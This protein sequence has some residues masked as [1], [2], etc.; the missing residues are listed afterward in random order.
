MFSHK[1]LVS[2]FSI[3]PDR[4]LE[5][6]GYVVSKS[7]TDTEIQRLEKQDFHKCMPESVSGMHLGGSKNGRRVKG[8]RKAD[9][10]GEEVLPGVGSYEVKMGKRWF[11]VNGKLYEKEKDEELVAVMEMD[12]FPETF[13]V[14]SQ[15]LMKIRPEDAKRRYKPAGKKVKPVA[16]SGLKP[17]QLG[18]GKTEEEIVAEM[19]ERKKTEP[20][21]V[22]AERL[23][24]MKIGKVEEGLL[25]PQERQLFVEMLL[26]NDKALA[27]VDAERGRVDPAIVPPARINT[28]PHTPWNYPAPRYAQKEEE[29]IVAYIKEK[30]KNFVAEFS[31][32]QYGNRWFVL[33]KKSGTLR[34]IQDLQPLNKVTVRDVGTVPRIDRILEK[35]AGR[36]IYTLLDMFSGYDEMGLHPDDRHLTA[37]HMPI[38]L[39]QLMVVPMGGTTSV[40]MFQRCMT[41]VLHD[42]QEDIEIYVDDIPVL[43]AT[44]DNADWTELGPGVRRVVSAHVEKVD[45]IL[46][47]IEGAN[48]T[49]SGLKSIFGVKKLRILGLECSSEGLRPEPNKVKVILEWSEEFKEVGDIY[50]FLGLVGWF[51]AHIQ[52]L[53]AKVE[54]LRRLTRRGVEW[55][56]GKEERET[57][58]KLKAEFADGGNLLV[59]PIFREGE[60]WK[61]IVESDWGPHG[62]GGHLA[63]RRGDEKDVRTVRFAGGTAS[64]AERN[65]SQV[66]G[67]VLAVKKA[68]AAFRHYIYGRP[69]ILRVDSSGAV[70]LLN[71]IPIIDPTL[72]RWI[73]FVKLFD[74]VVE[75][76]PSK[77]NV[78][79][80]A[81]SRRPNSRDL[82]PPADSTEE[83]E[84]EEEHLFLSGAVKKDSLDSEEDQLEEDQEMTLAVDDGGLGDPLVPGPEGK[85]LVGFRKDSYGP[86]WWDMGHYLSTAERPE[87]LSDSQW[88]KLRKC[89]RF[90]VLRSGWLF[91]WPKGHRRFGLPMPQRVVGRKEEQWDIIAELHDGIVG[92]HRDAERTRREILKLYWWGK[93]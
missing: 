53:P 25:T 22:T 93:I 1:A 11:E 41:I 26:S 81:L 8:G 82:P 14:V 44:V 61:F 63:Q 72:T 39:V 10:I 30:M 77:A 87:G 85:E 54:V 45:A 21:R 68:L 90:F 74:F 71:N 4:S 67:E 27:F 92:G 50:K 7:S 13:E 58:K 24:K 64:S 51:R 57:V 12:L 91:R 3:V 35:C 6:V 16:K 52:N 29:E 60:E 20:N 19:R 83:E 79:A 40:P 70:G 33:R 80:D 55:Q 62:W 36:A 66:K 88:K 17:G 23:E 37:M 49:A 48:M 43:G 32:S 42:H 5:G 76:I 38:G 34:W 73:G 28:I 65:Y 56:W 9:S 75:R 78:V 2:S 84:E 59:S 18:E 15:A 86:E 47:T 69:F 31:H 46:K 89:A